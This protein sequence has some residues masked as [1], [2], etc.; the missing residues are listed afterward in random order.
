[1]NFFS[2][3]VDPIFVETACAIRSESMTDS[4]FFVTV[5]VCDGM[6]IPLSG[7]CSDFMTSCR[8]G[9]AKGVVGVVNAGAIMN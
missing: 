9:G 8:A 7:L 1:M 6:S 3:G 2:V 5:G 4:V